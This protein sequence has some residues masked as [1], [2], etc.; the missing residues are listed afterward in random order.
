MTEFSSDIV[1]EIE[2]LE[3]A[4]ALSLP[5]GTI[6]QYDPETGV[7]SGV[8]RVPGIKSMSFDCRPAAV[9]EVASGRAT[10]LA[11]VEVMELDGDDVVEFRATL[12]DQ[13]IMSGQ[14]RV[15]DQALWFDR[16]AELF[17]L[18]PV[19]RQHAEDNACTPYPDECV[20]R[21]VN[22]RQLRSPAYPAECEYVRVVV[23]GVEVAYWDKQ[24]FA[25]ATAE[26]LGALVGCLYGPDGG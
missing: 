25:D 26:V 7:V 21:L 22:G 17:C 23:G 4:R 19:E 3:T 8:A 12:S 5:N 10:F 14:V 24:E 11:E 13:A 20:V 15:Q 6:V 16:V 2:G 9:A 1:S 18:S